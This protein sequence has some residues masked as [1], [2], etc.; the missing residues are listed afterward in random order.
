MGIKY[1]E[2]RKMVFNEEIIYIFIF[3]ENSLVVVL[4][5]FCC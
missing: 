1:K 2:G 3:N 4:V 5:I